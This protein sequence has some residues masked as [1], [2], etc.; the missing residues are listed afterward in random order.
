MTPKALFLADK[1]RAQRHRD[2]LQAVELHEDLL[3][4]FN[5]LCYS[6]L[7]SST[8]PERVMWSNAMREGA[9]RFIE[10]FLTLS[11]KPVPRTPSKTGQLLNPDASYQQ[12]H[13]R[14]TS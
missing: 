6:E 13:G 14:P 2:R 12:R 9:K 10:T 7:P 11:D 3:T 5:E 4:A 8:S 1:S